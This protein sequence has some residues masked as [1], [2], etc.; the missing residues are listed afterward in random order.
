MRYVERC[1]FLGNILHSYSSVMVCVRE[2]SELV[3]REGCHSST[4]LKNKAMIFRSVNEAA[5]PCNRFETKINFMKFVEKKS[6]GLIFQKEYWTAVNSCHRVFFF[7]IKACGQCHRCTAALRLI[8]Q[9]YSPLCFSR[10]HFRRLV[11]PCL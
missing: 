10:S 7:V 5:V 11:P 1:G 4:A 8:V 3:M 9:P 6:S 2:V